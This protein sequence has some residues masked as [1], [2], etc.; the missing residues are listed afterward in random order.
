MRCWTERASNDALNPGKCDTVWKFGTFPT[1]SDFSSRP[2][3]RKHGINSD[4]FQIQ[5]R[6]HL[7]IKS[8]LMNWQETARWTVRGTAAKKKRDGVSSLTPPPL[9]LSP[10]TIHG[11]CM[12]QF[13]HKT[14]RDCKLSWSR[15]KTTEPSTLF[16]F[17]VAAP[18]KKRDGV[19]SL[20]LLPHNR[21]SLYG[22]IYSQDGERLCKLSWK[23]EKNK[24]SPPPSSFHWRQEITTGSPRA[25]LF[26]MKAQLSVHCWTIPE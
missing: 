9:S 12:Y 23:S 25:A 19:F 7:W 24:C 21:P 5:R 16:F 20:S 8:A 4:V 15:R 26:E 18:N 17:S 2:R 10:T 6:T 14:A 3:K 13:T 11:A 1:T 22:S